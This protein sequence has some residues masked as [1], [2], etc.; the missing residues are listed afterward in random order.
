MSVLEMSEEE[1]QKIREQHIAATKKF[2]DR[3]QEL[4]TGLKKPEEKPEE[5]PIK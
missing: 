5:K 2:L 1:K 4:K 3:K